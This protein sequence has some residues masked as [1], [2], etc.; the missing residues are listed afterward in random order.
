M[1]SLEKFT[2]ICID[3][4]EVVSVFSQD[5]LSFFQNFMSTIGMSFV[6]EVM[7]GAL[8]NQRLPVSS[9]GILQFVDGQGYPAGDC[10]VVLEVEEKFCPASHKLNHLVALKSRNQA[11]AISNQPLM[12]FVCV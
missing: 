10:E 1:Q 12:L 5:F 7:S 4:I 3:F 11:E 8:C 2:S 6:S 9:A